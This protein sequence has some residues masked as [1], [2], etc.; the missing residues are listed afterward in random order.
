MLKDR[1]SVIVPAYNEEKN[2]VFVIKDINKLRKKYDI[3]LIVVDDASSDRT[4]DVAGNNGADLVLRHKRNGGKGMGFRT[5]IRKCTGEFVVQIDADGQLKASDI[6]KLIGALKNGADIVLGARYGVRSL[7]GG[8][9][10]S[11][12]KMLG[13]IF[14]SGMTSLFT[15]SAVIDVMTGLKAFRKQSLKHIVP[16]SNDFAY[17]AEIVVLA[18]RKKLKMNTV[19]ISCRKRQTGSSNLNSL[20]H[21][22]AVLKAIVSTSLS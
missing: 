9:F 3:Q 12:S 5:G 15:Q 13:N 6:P 7:F 8:N 21:G 1:I 14:L 16:S 10:T 22:F 11:R 18:H 19:Q 4:A 20:K 17:E 2:I